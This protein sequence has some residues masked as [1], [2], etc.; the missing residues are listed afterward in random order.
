MRSTSLGARRKSSS[1]GGHRS[2]S[3][4]VHRKSSSFRRSLVPQ[5]DS[6]KAAKMIDELRKKRIHDIRKKVNELCVGTDRKSEW[7]QKFKELRKFS[8]EKGILKPTDL[9]HQSYRSLCKLN[10]GYV[11]RKSLCCPEGK[12]TCDPWLKGPC[13]QAKSCKNKATHSID[14]TRESMMGQLAPLK[15]VLG[16]AYIRQLELEYTG[17]QCCFYCDK[18]YTQLQQDHKIMAFN[19]I[20][21]MASN[22]V[23][24]TNNWNLLLEVMYNDVVVTERD[25]RGFPVH[26][27]WGKKRNL[28]DMLYRMF[29]LGVLD[30]TGFVGTKITPTWSSLNSLVS[31]GWKA[32]L[33]K[34]AFGWYGV[35]IGSLERLKFLAGFYSLINSLESQLKKRL[36]PEN[37]NHIL[38]ALRSGFDDS[39]LFVTSMIPFPS[40]AIKGT[41]RQKEAAG[42]R[43]AA[44]GAML[45][46]R[47]A[48]LFTKS[49]SKS[50][51]QKPPC[52]CESTCTKG[53]C[54]IH[55]SS[56]KACEDVFVKVNKGLT[57]KP[58]VACD[59]TSIP[60]V[61]RPFRKLSKRE[62]KALKKHFK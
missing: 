35:I 44:K 32:G 43:Y 61:E 4:S 47:T 6:K 53:W 17:Q 19:W 33:K 57:G 41:A 21:G 14:L 28:L 22:T 30:M 60:Q 15:S 16:S 29:L 54:Y 45:A 48:E 8:V 10:R 12:E 62:K 24:Y 51:S 40:L 20:G 5:S 37:K 25:R 50:R 23:Y 34:L 11:L 9:S 46:K 1:W 38:K 58:W 13:C 18:H 49:R 52:S 3:K 27:T 2:K 42:L 7:G 59:K 56:Q 31:S 36:E 26:A 39:L 55:P